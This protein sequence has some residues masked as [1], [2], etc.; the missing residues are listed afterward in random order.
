MQKKIFIWAIFI[1]LAAAGP[2]F[3]EAE[4]LDLDFKLSSPKDPVQL[5]YLGLDRAESFSLDQV[6]ADILIVEIFSMYCPVCQREAKNINALFDRI[7]Q[8]KEL[9]RRVKLIGIGAGNSE[10]EVAFFKE[11]YGIQFP[12]FSDS[13]F[14]IHKKI[15]EVR[16]PFFIGL[17]LKKE[18]FHVFFT[19]AGEIKNHEGFLEEILSA[20]G[21]DFK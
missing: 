14:T 5:E 16:T 3:G 2:G 12:L 21:L 9:N 11:N 7:R 10:F 19:H 6:R 17:E 20:S 1:F 8:K 4:K 13:D 18:G 15:G